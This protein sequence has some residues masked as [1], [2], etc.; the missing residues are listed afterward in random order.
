MMLDALA[1]KV[2]SED[3]TITMKTSSKRSKVKVAI[4][5]IIANSESTQRKAS[6][7]TYSITASASSKVLISGAYLII[8]PQNEGIV[9]STDAKFYTTV[10]RTLLK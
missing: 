3:P 7:H 1:N 6:T 5:K 8:D 4:D 2:L 10:E 9:L